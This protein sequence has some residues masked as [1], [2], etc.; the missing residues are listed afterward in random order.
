MM[1]AM[2]GASGLGGTGAV[3]AGGQQ[4]MLQMLENPQMQ[5]QMAHMLA[6]PGF[7]ASSSL[8]LC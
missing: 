5:E 8:L 7:L 4:A 1:G 6:M 2:G 3:D